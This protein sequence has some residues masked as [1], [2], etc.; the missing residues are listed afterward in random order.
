FLAPAPLLISIFLVFPALWTLYLGV[1][2]FRLSGSAAKNP[3]FVGS[4]TT[5]TPSPT[6]VF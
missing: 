2:N 1:T 3:V 4:I 6:A 5:S